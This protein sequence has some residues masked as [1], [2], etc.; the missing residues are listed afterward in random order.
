M[1]RGWV[2][3]RYES[4]LE[5][6]LRFVT[7][8]TNPENCLLL[9]LVMTKTVRRGRVLENCLNKLLVLTKSTVFM[10]SVNIIFY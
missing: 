1:V 2:T 4:W 9:P 8:Q 5:N 10:V 7:G 6:A 3:A